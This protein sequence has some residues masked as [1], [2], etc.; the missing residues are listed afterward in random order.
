MSYDKM[1][2]QHFV[3]SKYDHDNDNDN[4]NVFILHNHT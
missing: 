4:D 1:F 2:R 3:I